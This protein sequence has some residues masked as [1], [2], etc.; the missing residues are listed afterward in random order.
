MVFVDAREVDDD[1]ITVDWG[2]ING[3]VMRNRFPEEVRISH[4]ISYCRIRSTTALTERHV[5]KVATLLMLVSRLKV[6]GDSWTQL[7]T[8]PFQEESS[9]CVG[10]TF[11]FS[12]H[13]LSER[14]IR[15]DQFLNSLLS[16]KTRRCE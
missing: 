3:K 15:L 14:F 2:E 7:L 5:R 11:W 12:A 4:L 9:A 6:A 10:K 16:S 1:S 13:Y 8:T